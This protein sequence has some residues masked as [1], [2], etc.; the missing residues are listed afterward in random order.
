MPKYKSNRFRGTQA[1][2]RNQ[3]RG[4]PWYRDF[5]D[6]REVLSPDLRCYV[7]IIRYNTK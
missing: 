1:T 7:C 2:S 3:K 4:L 6:V 5:L